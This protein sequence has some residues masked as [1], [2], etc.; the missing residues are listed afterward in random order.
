MLLHGSTVATNAVLEHKF[1]GLGPA[2]D[3]RLPAHDRDRPP[4]RAG[5]LRQFLLLGEAAAAGAAA[6]R[7]RGAGAAALRRLGDRADRR[8][9]DARARCASWSRTASDAS[10]SACCTPTPTASTSGGSASSSA[11]NFPGVFVSLSSVVLPEYREYERAMTTLVD[12]LVK[13]YCK[14]YLQSAAD[15]IRARSGDMPFLIMQS[16]GGVVKHSTAGERPVT[17]LLSGPAA[18]MLGSIHMATARRLQEH[19]DHRRR[20]HLDGRRHH[21]ET[22]T[23]MYTSASHG[24]ELSR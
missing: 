4:V 10:P 1:E 12:V 15:K 5:R 6:P 7:P 16:N 8:G 3:A 22:Q 11:K 20:R 13:P 9:G 24:G 17:M 14:T 21:R 18:G 2:G 19:P 23:P